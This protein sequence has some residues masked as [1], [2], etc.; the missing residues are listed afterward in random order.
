MVGASPAGACANISFTAS[1]W[2]VTLFSSFGSVTTSS[3]GVRTWVCTFSS[4][5]RTS[6]VVV[7]VVS[8]GVVAV[9]SATVVVEDSS[10]TVVEDSSTI[11]VE[12]SSTIDDEDS[13]TIDVED[14]STGVD[15][16]V[17]DVGTN[18]GTIDATD[19]VPVVNER[20]GLKKLTLLETAKVAV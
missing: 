4:S 2:I 6:G 5:L 1:G 14:S 15:E 18:V 12:D 7:E 20:T 9:F 16:D 3:M 13:L 19:S 17:D 8:S 10:T 11:D